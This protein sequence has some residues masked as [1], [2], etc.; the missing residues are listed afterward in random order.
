MKYPLSL[1]GIALITSAASADITGFGGLDPA[2]WTTNVDDDGVPI[3]VINDDLIHFTSGAQNRRSMWH[4]TPQDITAFEVSFTYL[5]ST[6]SASGPRQGVTFTIQNAGLDALGTSLGYEGITPSL[7][8][9]IETSTGPGLTFTGVYT[10]GVIG[11]SLPVSPVN[12]FDFQDIDVT[13]QYADSRVT[14]HM[15]D[16]VNS[17]DSP[18]FIVDD[19]TS[20]LGGSEGFVGFTG[21]TA[22]GSDQFLSNFRFTT[23]PAPGSLPV[24]SLLGISAMRRRRV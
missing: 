16:G 3:G 2:H 11:S 10:N 22:N 20:I 7:A 14:V 1:A 21:S 19:L 8:V 6:I 15:T 24:L 12:A 13:I 17:Y 4:N 23:V 9:S 5:A 18:S